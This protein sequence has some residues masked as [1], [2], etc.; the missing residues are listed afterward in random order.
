[1]DGYSIGSNANVKL[2]Q[3]LLLGKI[4]GIDKAWTMLVGGRSS[5][6][7]LYGARFP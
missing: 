7:G 2:S 6:A 3:Y 4:D 5:V 1:M